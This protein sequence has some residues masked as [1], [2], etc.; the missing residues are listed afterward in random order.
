M[1]VVSRSR[2]ASSV[3]MRTSRSARQLFDSRSQSSRSGMRRVGRLSSDAWI[4]ASEIP[5][6][7]PAWMNASRR[8]TARS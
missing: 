1:Q 4:A 5:A 8:S 6:A 3:A 7:R 2:S